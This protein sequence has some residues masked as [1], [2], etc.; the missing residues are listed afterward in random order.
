MKRFLRVADLSASSPEVD[1]DMARLAKDYRMTDVR[2]IGAGVQFFVYAAEHPRYGKVAIRLPRFRI[3]DTVNDQSV[4]S[5]LLIEQEYTIASVLSEAGLPTA[6]PL[7]KRYIADG[8]P[9]LMSSFISTDGST[10]DWHD[11]GRL[12]ARLHDL[13]PLDGIPAHPAGVAVADLVA[14]RLASRMASLRDIRPELP[15][16]PSRIELAVRLA[17]DCQPTSLLHLDVRRD[18]L[19]CESGRVLALIDWSNALVGDPRLE[20]ARMSEYAKIEE[21]EVDEDAFRA[22]YR[23]DGRLIGEGNAIDLVYRLDAAVMLALVFLDVVPKPWLAPAQVSRVGCLV[24][25]LEASW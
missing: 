1:E 16:I 4:N 5:A 2:L 10:P 9:M 20:L 8:L 25:Q 15:G 17:A 12:F 21:N 14:E 19:L 13:P 6:R 11:V 24:R 18:N 22:G 3:I 7:E 23:A